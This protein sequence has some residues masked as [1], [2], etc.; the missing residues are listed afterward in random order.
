M[1]NGYQLVSLIEAL[2]GP[3]N[4]PQM[5]LNTQPP[6]NNA[7]IQGSVPDVSVTEQPATAKTTAVAEDEVPNAVKAAQSLNGVAEKNNKNSPHDGDKEVWKRG[8]R[9]NGIVGL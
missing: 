9:I 2:N 7:R 6:T 5:T 4:A 3:P 8:R 1:P